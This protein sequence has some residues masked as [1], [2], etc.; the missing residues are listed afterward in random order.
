MQ[1]YPWH[2]SGQSL[3]CSGGS[4]SL[5]PHIQTNVS[6]LVGVSSTS[7]T[8]LLLS[9]GR[10]QSARQLLVI[11][12]NGFFSSES[13]LRQKKHLPPKR[14]LQE[15]AVSR[16]ERLKLVACL[17]WPP[18]VHSDRLSLWELTVR[19]Q[20]KR[21]ALTSKSLLKNTA[22]CWRVVRREESRFQEKTA[23]SL[24][25]V[26]SGLAT[27]APVLWSQSVHLVGGEHRPPS[28][29]YE[30]SLMARRLQQKALRVGC[31]LLKSARGKRVDYAVGVGV[32]TLSELSS[33]YNSNALQLY[34]WTKLS[35]ALFHQSP[36]ELAHHN[37]DST[38]TCLLR[39]LQRS[40]T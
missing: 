19:L 3:L 12:K 23:L 1:L 35:Q 24:E 20:E 36:C 40:L 9:Q 27:A 10:D 37:H 17:R 2:C 6:A 15:T 28:L 8:A 5:L 32:I 13:D 4:G 14:L 33:G 22:S 26:L 31:R 25:G 18:S 34:R 11:T 39:S 38:R 16:L 7:S 29:F 30:A 21:H